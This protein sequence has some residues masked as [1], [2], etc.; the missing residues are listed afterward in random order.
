MDKNYTRWAM[1]MAI[2]Y[3]NHWYCSIGMPM[4]YD[5]GLFVN[6]EPFEFDWEYSQNVS[7]RIRQMELME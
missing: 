3:K 5:G 4:L 2:I 7:G 6:R 1:E